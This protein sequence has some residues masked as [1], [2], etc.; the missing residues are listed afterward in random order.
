MGEYIFLSNQMLSRIIRP[1]PLTIID[2]DWQVNK[3]LLVIGYFKVSF[4]QNFLKDIRELHSSGVFIQR[5]DV[6]LSNCSWQV[7]LGQI[8]L[9][10]VLFPQTCVL[11]LAFKIYSHALLIWPFSY[12]QNQGKRDTMWH[13]MS[14]FTVKGTKHK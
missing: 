1:L 6:Q 10:H 9:H 5:R 8:Q 14:V 7:M 11:V 4:W 3:K 2:H 12:F 13:K